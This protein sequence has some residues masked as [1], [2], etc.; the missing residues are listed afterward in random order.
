MVSYSMK[1]VCEKT[2]LTAHTL[3]YYEKEGLLTGIGRT[4]GGLRVYTDGDLETLGLVCCL[5]STGMPLGEIARF[6]LLTR[7]GKHT[8]KERCEILKLHRQNVLSR[9]EEMQKHLD[10]VTWKLDF[11]SQ[12]L[13]DYEGAGGAR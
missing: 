11:Y 6:I 10:K 8:L 12:K 13:K 9:M 5:K 7:E 3:R 1:E 4:K 2:G